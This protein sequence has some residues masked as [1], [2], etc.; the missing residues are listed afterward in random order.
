MAEMDTGAK[1]NLK[2]RARRAVIKCK[3][4]R[5]FQICSAEKLLQVK[6]LFE[7]VS[8]K[9]SFEGREGRVVT[10]SKRK[11]IPDLESR[12]AK[13]MTTMLFSF[14]EGDVKGS[15]IRRRAQRPKRDVD[16]DKFSQV[17]RGSTSDDLIAEASY[18]VFNSLFYGEPM[19]LLEQ[20]FGMFEI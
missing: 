20:R 15:I 6:I 16:L 19:Q 9:A 18:F 14:E 8:F 1:T 4:E 3:R 12:K 10:E 13:G 7:K 5:E 11:R 17:L 2:A